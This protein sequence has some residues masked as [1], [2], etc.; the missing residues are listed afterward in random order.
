VRAAFAFAIALSMALSALFIGG[1]GFTDAVGVDENRGST[2]GEELQ[3]RTNADDTT[4][5]S[6]ARSENEGSVAGFIIS[7]ISDVVDTIWLV[8]VLPITLR[9]LGFPAWFANPVGFGVYAL[10][11]VGIAQAAAGRYFR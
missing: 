9:E 5:N 6:S 2:I 1:S 11:S 3:D 8:I 4:F 7:G 10:V